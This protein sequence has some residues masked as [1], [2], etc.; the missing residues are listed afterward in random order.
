ML[1]HTCYKWGMKTIFYVTNRGIKQ[2]LAAHNNNNNNNNNNKGLVNE[3]SQGT[4]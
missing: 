1:V 2:L 3:Y 4:L